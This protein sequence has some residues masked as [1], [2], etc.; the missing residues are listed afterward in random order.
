MHAT[1]PSV[2]ARPTNARRR[3]TGTCA[4]TCATSSILPRGRYTNL[5]TDLL[6]FNRDDYYGTN[7]PEDIRKSPWLTF[8]DTQVQSDVVVRGS[9]TGTV[10][11]DVPGIDC[12]AL[13]S[14][15]WN[16]GA[17][18]TLTATPGPNTRFVRWSGVCATTDE[19][20]EVT[21]AAPVHAEAVFAE[22]VALTLTVDASRAS[23]TVVSTPAGLSC[24]GTCT[25]RFDKGQLVTLTARPGTGSQLEQW[26]GACSGRGVCTVAVDAP[27][28]VTAAFASGTRRLATSVAGKGRIV[29]SPSGISCPT[30]CAATF[31]VET[32]V[33]LKAVPAKGYVLRAWTGACKGHA[34]CSVTLGADTTV[35]ATFKRR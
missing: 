24:P 10:Q 27:T 13:C 1:A 29:S 4:T 23:G 22:Q 11:S 26:G 30:K 31:G 33:K 9:G 20:C 28:T 19:T 16:Q 35:R 7:G 14:N 17:T 21:A 6:D 12:P 32:T 18:F 8:L 3:T 5:N 15:Q 25:A 34:G 2:P